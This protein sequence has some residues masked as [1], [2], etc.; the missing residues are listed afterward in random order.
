MQTF[1]PPSQ[2]PG[3]FGN[4]FR[5][6]GVLSAGLVRDIK[7]CCTATWISMLMGVWNSES[8]VHVIVGACC[9]VAV[10]VALY[11]GERA[12]RPRFRLDQGQLTD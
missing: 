2:V 11:N 4:L 9:W 6:L 5:A 1:D 3:V 12:L 8:V 7:K 10:R